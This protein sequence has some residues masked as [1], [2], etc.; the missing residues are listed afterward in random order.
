MS[1]PDS[2]NKPIDIGFRLSY[3]KFALKKGWWIIAIGI[4]L[5]GVI[6]IIS[7]LRVPNEYEF[8]TTFVMN[9]SEAKLEF[10]KLQSE[11]RLINTLRTDRKFQMS[12]RVDLG[13]R[14]MSEMYNE[15]PFDI[16]IEDLPEYYLD[17]PHEVKLFKDESFEIHW[18]VGKEA[19]VTK[20]KMGEEAKIGHSKLKV[21]KT[22]YWNE[23][24]SDQAYDV[25][26]WSDEELQRRYSHRL[27]VIYL[28]E[29]PNRIEIGFVDQ[30]KQ[31]AF[32]FL[33]VYSKAYIEEQNRLRNRGVE[34][35][36]WD[37]KKEKELIESEILKTQV[38]SIGVA[39]IEKAI[40][41][42]WDGLSDSLELLLIQEQR[43]LQ[44]LEIWNELKGF[45]PNIEGLLNR[46]VML[47]M[48]KEDEEIRQILSSSEQADGLQDALEEVQ[49]RDEQSLRKLSSALISEQRGQARAYAMRPFFFDLTKRSVDNNA[50]GKDLILWEHYLAVN[51]LMVEG[52]LEASKQTNVMV[53]SD[54]THLV[55]GTAGLKRRQKAIFWVLACFFLAIGISMVYYSSGTLTN[56]E[57]LQRFSNL[58]DVQTWSTNF[59]DL[60]ERELFAGLDIR[61]GKENKVIALISHR[62]SDDLT[63][64][65]K[66]LEKAFSG[67]GQKCL[68][69]NAPDVDAEHHTAIPLDA[70][71]GW[72]MSK[73]AKE[74]VEQEGESYD[75]IIV[76]LPSL[77]ETPESKGY[78]RNSDH[79]FYFIVG[80]QSTTEDLKNWHKIV[81]NTAI[82]ST[83]F[84]VG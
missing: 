74:L 34:E 71:I 4:L 82:K 80:G 72:W 20:A 35:L 68:L 52:R 84:F 23:E 61:L 45:N 22:K 18:K 43:L 56:R 1:K 40:V 63:E 62:Q 66:A 78:L 59:G 13:W 73:D 3:V 32:D 15:S 58:D 28:V 6:G 36:F 60:Q 67:F 55:L 9:P 79:A 17:K 76:C 30:N 42:E 81:Q 41:E 24:R 51:Q 44:R 27:E 69:V 75:R 2:N 47:G 38:S 77:S 46:L 16:I 64:F 65:V 83:P 8:R 49:K 19:I 50:S 25:I 10:E 37:A 33:N 5:G 12:R 14:G 54:P 11:T 57:Q 29:R 70:A 48:T 21:L 26:F 39:K 53:E 7:A 31:R